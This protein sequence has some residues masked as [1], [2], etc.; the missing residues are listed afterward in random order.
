MIEQIA[1]AVK[2]KN[3]EGI[4]DLRDELKE[5]K[6]EGLMTYVREHIPIDEVV[7]ATSE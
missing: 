4:S 3:I 7:L 2:N 6:D 5:Q 1:E